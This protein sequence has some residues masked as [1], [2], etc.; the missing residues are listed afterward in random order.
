ML[1]QWYNL[2]HSWSDNGV[3]AFPKSESARHNAR[4]CELIYFE[5]AV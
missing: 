4:E 2:T 3:H 5:A 1:K